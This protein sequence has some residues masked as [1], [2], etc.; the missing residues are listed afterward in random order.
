MS[1]VYVVD[2]DAHWCESADA[3]TSRVPAKYR[4]RAPQARVIDG[5][6]QW[7]ING[8]VPFGGA[9]ACVIDTEG[10]KRNAYGEANMGM[11]SIPRLEL[12]TPAAYQ[13]QERVAYMDEYGIWAE[14]IYPNLAGFSAAKFM[15]AFRDDYDLELACIKAYNDYGAEIQAES[16]QRLFPLALVPARQ[17]KDAMV[18]MRRCHEELG[19]VGY[20]ISDNLTALGL[21]DYSHPYWQPFFEY[22]NAIG[23]NFNFHTGGTL[24]DIGRAIWRKYPPA[25]RLALNTTASNVSN[26]S[27]MGNILL[28]GLHDR[29]PNIKWVSV[30]SGIGWVPGFLELLDHNV[31]AMVPAQMRRSEMLPSEAF[32]RHWWSCF[33]FEDAAP[34][35]SLEDIGYDRVLFETDFPHPTCLYPDNR[36][37]VDRV[38]GHLEPRVRKMILQDNAVGVYDLPVPR[39]V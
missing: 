13:V 5:K 31:K 8:S 14:M 23:A 21:P 36:G 33:W 24:L 25:E 38:L 39:P 32:R 29:Y 30:E 7:F 3:W 17:M 11:M 19:L 34:L 6:T 12:C 22:G 15:R 28:S 10:G 20:V 9:P 37:Y 16:G 1:D 2:A 4:D 27:V 26:A 35:N 18:E